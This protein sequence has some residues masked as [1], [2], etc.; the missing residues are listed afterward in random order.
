MIDKLHSLIG[1]TARFATPREV[2]ELLVLASKGEGLTHAIRDLKHV[3]NQYLGNRIMDDDRQKEF[4]ELLKTREDLFTA[5]AKN[6]EQF[7]K[8]IQKIKWREE[9]KK[10]SRGG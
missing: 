4:D 9:N 5:I 7:T 10:R 6:K 2:E 3:C 1:N 8:M